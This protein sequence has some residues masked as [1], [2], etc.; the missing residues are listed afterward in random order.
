MGQTTARLFCLFN[1]I[2]ADVVVMQAGNASAAKV[3]PQLD[4][5]ILVSW[6]EG[7]ITLVMEVVDI[8]TEQELD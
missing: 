8:V 1:A 3:L 5:D 4:R 2:T 7:L 6:P